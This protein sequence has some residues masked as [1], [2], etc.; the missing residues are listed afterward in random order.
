[1][2]TLFAVTFLAPGS[3]EPMMGSMKEEESFPV[4]DRVSSLLRWE[5]N[6]WG[7]RGGTGDDEGVRDG[8]GVLFPTGFTCNNRLTGGEKKKKIIK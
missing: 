6:D 5:W 3:L 2:H 4:A 1:M 7:D 8:G